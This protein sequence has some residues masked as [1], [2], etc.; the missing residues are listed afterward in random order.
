MAFDPTKPVE[1]TEIDAAELRNQLNA[2][3][4]LIDAQAAQIAAL[5]TA[6]NA[7]PSMDDVNAAIAANSSANVNSMEGLDNSPSDPPTQGDVLQL[8]YFGNN[9]LNA[10][11]R[12]S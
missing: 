5:Q 6:L 7:K 4:A 1:Q 2:L 3:K 8:Y 9:L 12:P 10:L 11:K